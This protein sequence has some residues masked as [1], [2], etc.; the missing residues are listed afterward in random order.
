M[1][2][3]GNLANVGHG[4]SSNFMA[5]IRDLFGNSSLFQM[6]PKQ[7][8]KIQK[9]KFR[10]SEWKDMTKEQAKEF[11]E[12][13]EQHLIEILEPI[14]NDYNF[15]LEEGLVTCVRHYEGEATMKK[16]IDGKDVRKRAD[17]WQRELGQKCFGI[18]VRAVSNNGKDVVANYCTKDRTRVR[19]P[20]CKGGIPAYRG[21]DL[22]R[23]EELYEWQRDLVSI[24]KGNP[25]PRT[26]YWI[27]GKKGGE[28]KTMMAKFLAYWHKAVLLTYSNTRD[29]LSMACEINSRCY[30]CDLTRA[31]PK[32]VGNQDLYSALE[33]IKNGFFMNSKYVT[34]QVTRA[35]PHVIV[36]SN[37]F[38]DYKS[39]SLDRWNVWDL[40]KT[41]KPRDL[42]K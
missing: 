17:T 3:N 4:Q 10:W 24:I 26:I 36:F 7:G 30:V 16:M 38:P 20:W 18:Q 11:N 13:G 39:M 34:K 22:P 40:S 21:E 12:L 33:G 32:D 15:Q 25:H 41:K 23:E 28:G 31:K 5:S 29:L 35:K 14:T 37:H 2:N 19:G 8:N 42:P 6:G 9:I 27:V 1:S